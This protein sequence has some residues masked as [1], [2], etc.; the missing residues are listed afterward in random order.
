MYHLIYMKNKWKILKYLLQNFMLFY[1]LWY[2]YILFLFELPV[3]YE[4]KTHMSICNHIKLLSSL[5][6]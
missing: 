1:Y 3:N 2:I 6:V 4:Q 5:L